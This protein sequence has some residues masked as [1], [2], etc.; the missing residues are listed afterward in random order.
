[1]IR[2]IDY[3]KDKT[4]IFD[5]LMEKED[6]GDTVRAI[7]DDVRKRGD[8]ALRE[9]TFRFD[10]ALVEDA[11]VSE[12]EIG[13]AFLKVETEFLNILRKAAFNIRSFHEK[14]KREGFRFE[15]EEGVV[16]GQKVMAIENVGLYIPGGTAA[17]PST[18]L[19]NAI[20]AKIAGC[21]RI[22]LISPPQED[23]KVDPL[24]VAAA[25][26]AGVDEI[27]KVGGAQGIA[28][29]AY[30]TKTI[31]KVDKIVGPGNKYVAEAKR[32]VF[33]MVAIDMIAGPSEILVISDG[34]SDPRFLA[35]DMLSQAEHDTDA[36]AVLITDS[37]KLAA[38]VQNEIENLLPGLERESIARASIERHGKIIIVESL[39]EAMDVANEIAPEHLELQ[40][41]DPFAWLD[42]V[43][44]AGSV[45]LGRNCPEAMGDYYAGPNHTLPTSGTAKFSSPLSVDDF[46]KK[47]QYI[48]YS[49]EALSRDY[50]DVASFAE[51]EGLTGHALSARI[52]NE[53]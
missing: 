53:G 3:T 26:I 43:R 4:L 22:V 9:Y 30:G 34:N 35:A 2:I 21:R 19:M 44:N 13:E 11:R 14:Q 5:R 25:K 49:D 8:A 36:S 27:Y 12:E 46:I 50:S 41:D 1:M 10:R 39:D 32:Q 37:K 20:P 33:G 31:R 45:F 28:A 51:K 15:R 24:I 18:V 47:T 6:V 40:L 38:E 52:R 29:L 7:L 17:Y 23:G 42:K 16:L 48:Y